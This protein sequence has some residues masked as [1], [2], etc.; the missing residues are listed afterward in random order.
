MPSD[1]L[2]APFFGMMLLTLIVWLYMY[3]RRLGYIMRE[4]IDAQSISTPERLARRIPEEINNASNNL[5]NLF[6]LP[7]LF[8]AVC[9][10]LLG[11]GEADSTDVALAWAFLGLRT[12]HSAVQ[13]TANVVALRFGAYLL[14]SLALFALVVRSAL[15]ALT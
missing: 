6:E 3:V 4:G 10:Y 2:L 9:L 8:Y 1:D 13:C 5:K 14:A 15:D 11:V 12:V 7:V